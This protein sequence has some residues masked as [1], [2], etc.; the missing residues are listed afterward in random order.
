M[1][2]P[3]VPGRDLVPLCRRAVKEAQRLGVEAEAFAS[4]AWEVE[5]EIDGSNITIG[6]ESMDFGV[7]VRVIKDKR[8]GFAYTSVPKDIPRTVRNA[9]SASRLGVRVDNPLP[10]M[11][12]L[13]DV[14]GLIHDEVMHIETERG[15]EL[16]REVLEGARSVSKDI[17]VPSGG[18][19]YGIERFA[20]VNTNGLE[21]DHVGTV[22]SAS[23]NAVAGEGDKTSAY[24]SVTSRALDIDMFEVGRKAAD[25]AVR[26]QGGK[27]LKGGKMDVVFTPP[28]L[29]ELMG[30]T[31]VPAFFGDRV[32]T[33]ESYLKGRLGKRI[34]CK[35]MDIEDDGLRPSGL[36]SARCD[37]EGS[38]SKRTVL[39]KDGVLKGFLYDMASASRYGAKNEDRD[40]PSSTGN[41][42]RPGFR[43]VPMTGSRN[44]SIHGRT[45][46]MEKIIASIDRGVLVHD[47]M[48]AHTANPASTDFSVNSP[49]LFMIEDGEVAYPVQSAMIS[50]NLGEMFMRVGALGDDTRCVAGGTAYYIPSVW[51]R[52]VQVTG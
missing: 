25:L 1:A 24:E 40:P 14:R 36:G 39:M 6:A 31:L 49:V 35:G 37:E 29:A 30:H 16:T 51:F 13:P 18:L 52:N 26:L 22:A 41:G 47:I 33:G 43:G 17:H 19:Y 2:R 15:F 8:L 5:T 50:G 3:K 23:A 48:G 21:V 32:A 45:R 4:M 46:A 7:G 38:P 11:T 34:A 20:I 9:L 27:G 44:V 12:K 28:A 10:S 42:L